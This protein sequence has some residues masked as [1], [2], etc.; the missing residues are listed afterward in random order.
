[1]FSKL[2]SYV[3]S[4][5]DVLPIVIEVS[6]APGLPKFEIIGLADTAIK[7]SKER[8]F[9][10]ILINGYTIPPGNIT[11]NLAPAK[12]KKKGSIYDLPIALGIL[13]ASQQIIN[14]KDLE[15]FIIAGELSL[16]G[17]IREVEGLFSAA[18]YFEDKKQ[19]IIPNKNINEVYSLGNKNIFPCKS[20]QEAIEIISEKKEV[21]LLEMLPKKDSQQNSKEEQKTTMDYGE[22]IGNEI[23]KFAI[24]LSVLEKL[25]ILFIGPPGCG[26]T[27]L[28]KRLPTILPKLN[29]ED[30][31]VITKIYKAVENIDYII[32]DTPFRIVHSSVSDIGLLGGG[33]YPKPGELSL[34]HKGYLFLDELSEYKKDTLQS[35]RI[36]IEQKLIKI[37]RVEQTITYP[38]DVTLIACTNPCTC[39]YYGDTVKMCRCNQNSLHRFYSKLS[40]PLLDRFDMTVFINQFDR[41]TLENSKNID[42]KTMMTNIQSANDNRK[43]FKF[44]YLHLDLKESFNRYPIFK[45]TLGLALDKKFISLRKVKSI[46]KTCKALQLYHN[47]NLNEDIILQ[48]IDLCRDKVVGL[49]NNI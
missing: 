20:F 12:I 8:I 17:L 47:E 3:L 42:S 10:S 6:I 1:M 13:I 48:A 38:C 41:E 37:N 11:I 36:P 43:N 5:I 7:E 40:G 24:Q 16:D 9:K 30:S 4:G 27:M 31:L 18:L 34:S 46:L 32:E 21:N 19:Y 29:H 2:H 22:V 26:K 23:A 28:A 49:L 33:H 15:K 44:D 25:N 35:L 39:G 45:N 14:K